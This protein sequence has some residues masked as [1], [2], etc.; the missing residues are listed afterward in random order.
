MIA[1]RRALFE[2]HH[3][4][5]HQRPMKH[6]VDFQNS[7]LTFEERI[8]APDKFDAALGRVVVSF[9]LLE[10]SVR[11]VICVLLNAPDPRVGYIVSAGM[12]FR[13]RLDV[14]GSLVRHRIASIPPLNNEQFSEQWFSELLIICS[15]AEELRNAYV[16]SSYAGNLRSKTTA[17]SKRGLHT[18]IEPASADLVLDVADY[19]V[20]VA[21]EVEGLPI[22]LGIADSIRSSERFTRYMLDQK[23]I[24]TYYFGHAPT[25]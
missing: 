9:S 19:I 16:H 23:V 17:R 24:A 15:R 12:G 22:W 11:N 6:V 3:A 5:E 20:S 4:C 2:E 10:D 13:Q 1:A 18:T 21:A 14:L 7:G 8:G 25:S